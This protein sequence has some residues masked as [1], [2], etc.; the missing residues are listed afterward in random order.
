MSVNPKVSA[1]VYSNSES[2]IGV[3]L[4]DGTAG[5][6]TP[7]CNDR[8]G[9]SATQARR[10]DPDFGGFRGGRRLRA[11]APDRLSHAIVVCKTGWNQDGTLKQAS[12]EVAI[13]SRTRLRLPPLQ[14]P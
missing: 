10:T 12:Q 9:M 14:G 2:S 1:C 7:D 4:V 3:P 5:V 6:V 13:G 11:R 8:T